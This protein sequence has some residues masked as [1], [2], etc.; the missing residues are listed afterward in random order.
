M[1]FE[2]RALVEFDGGFLVF[3]FVVFCSP[4]SGVA[5]SRAISAASRA[6]RKRCGLS[7][8]A[9]ELP[10]MMTDMLNSGYE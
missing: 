8:L 6:V 2:S 1:S 5:S 9:A 3:F 10:D 7:V 4:S